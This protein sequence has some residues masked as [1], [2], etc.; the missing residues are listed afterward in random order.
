MQGLWR[1]TDGALPNL[2]AL[3][4]AVL[5]YLFG[6][7]LIINTSPWANAAGTLLLAHAMVIAAYLIHECAHNTV[8]A[9]N[10]HNAMLGTALGWLTGSCYANYEDVR[11]KHFRHHVDRGDVV[12]FD[13][14]E[15]LARH[16]GLL[17]LMA[18][19]E[20][21]YIPA[22]ELMMHA[23]IVIL[24]FTDPN[25][26][27]RRARVA[28]ITL[29]RAGV[30]GVL[31]WQAPRV[32]LLY[33]LA[34]IAFLTVMRFMDAHQHT[35]EIFATLDRERGPEARRF[36]AAY[37]ERNTFSNLLSVKHPWLNLLVLNFCYHNAHHSRP[38][39]PW[40]RLPA[41]HRELHGDEKGH[42]DQILPFSNL[43]YAFH[44]YRVPRML[45]ADA[46]DVSV[47]QDRGRHFI[48]VDGVS[49]MTTH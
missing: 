3:G 21:C 49:F 40:Y 31:A 20:W 38:T 16:P 8:F 22:V 7:V 25:R 27:H 34:Y 4:Y 30:F 19:L 47:Q 48:G 45:N 28:L 13:Y 29:V 44:R 10:Q 42:Y 14:R 32:L 6:F 5:G 23:L 26:R 37:E 18:A 46:G 33:P 41:L 17:R 36:G 15:R 24:P 11:H 2:L 39:A 35:Y 1:H 43:L 9:R 12:A